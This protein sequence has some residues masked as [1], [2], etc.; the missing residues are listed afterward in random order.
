M[1]RYLGFLLVALSAAPAFTNPIDVT[2]S[3]NFGAPQD[4]SSVFDNQNYAINF[5]IPDPAS[6]SDTTCCLF[7]ISAAYEVNVHLAVP[8]I[9]LSL[10]NVLQVQYNSQ[11]PLGEWLNIVSFTGL[12]VGDFMV[13]SP[14]QINSGELWNGLAGALGTPVINPLNGAPGTGIWHL[15]QNTQNVGPI[16]IAVYNSAIFITAAEVP[17]PAPVWLLAG[18]LAALVVGNLARQV[19]VQRRFRFRPGRRITL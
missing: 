14:F 12:P 4:G 10:D 13:L 5:V 3:G 15:E 17:E 1:Y 8:A 16:P 7:Q 11:L 19:P 6:P 9:G 2:L 18:F